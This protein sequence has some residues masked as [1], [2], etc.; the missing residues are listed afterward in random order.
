MTYFPRSGRWEIGL[1]KGVLVH[2]VFHRLVMVGASLAATT[3]GAVAGA[4]AETV[5]DAP[6][7][8]PTVVLAVDGTKGPATADSIDPNSPLNAY[9]GPFQGRPDFAVRHIRYPGGM[10]AGIN[11][12]DTDMDDSVEIGATR[13]RRAIA[14]TETTCGTSTHY[15][16]YGY[17]QGALVVRKV[18]TE[19]DSAERHREDGTELQDRVRVHLIADP[20]LG[21]PARYPGELIPG[22]T[23]PEPAT[24]FRHIQATTECLPGDIVC[25]PNGDLSGYATKHGAY[26]PGV[27]AR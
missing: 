12:W 11:G 21:V 10:I 19:L 4:H 24:P 26:K 27:G 25:D 7:C 8:A 15:E 23:L 5:G 3:L 1:L 6:V 2:S 9:V 17:S 20:A 18:A 14:Y 22:I 16:L 13:L